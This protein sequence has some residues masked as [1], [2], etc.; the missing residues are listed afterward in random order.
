[1]PCYSPLT[2]Y[3]SETE[4]TS[5]GKKAI[6]FKEDNSLSQLKLPC[7]QCIGCRLERSRQWAIRCMHEAQL[8]ENNCFLTLTIDK[9]KSTPEEQITLKKD[10]YQKFMKRLRKKYPEIKISYYYCGEYGEQYSRPHYHSCLFNFDFPDKSLYRVTSDGNRLYTSEL[11][12]K[13]WGKGNCYIGDVTF[14]SAAYVAR[15]ITKKITGP[16][17]DEYYSGRL[18]EYTNMS[19]KPAI[20]LRW[21]Q[22]YASDVYPSDEVILRGKKVRPARYYDKYMETNF[23]LNFDLVKMKREE[24]AHRYELSEE[25]SQERL[26]VKHQIQMLRFKKLI[27]PLESNQL[28]NIHHK[29]DYDTN[30]INYFKGIKP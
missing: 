2:A 14:E 11:L 26:T 15:Y 10:L 7:G 19:K 16:N 23:P 3:R 13:L 8:H 24:L 27:R 5:T 12:N 28:E 25:S 9:N 17:S 1:M 6:Q 21:I 22:Q 4:L 29:N 30:V 20:G 18:P